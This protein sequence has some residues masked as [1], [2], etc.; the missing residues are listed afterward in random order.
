MSREMSMQSSPES[1]VNC[2]TSHRKYL[3][4]YDSD[5][6]PCTRF[7]RTI[8]FLDSY[9]RFEFVSL[10]R[11]EEEGFLNEVPAYLRKRSFHLI[12]SDGRTLSGAKALPKLI[13][14][15]PCGRYF[16][17]I[18]LG[19]PG[20][21]RAIGFVYGV[22]SRLHDSGSCTFKTEQSMSDAAMEFGILVARD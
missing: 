20:G 7:K 14:A 21:F 1:R 19:V 3:V 15:L 12:A 10:S 16:S 22:L 17:K 5:C 11:A 9:G 2:V 6:G 18:L 4:A 13:S 8:E